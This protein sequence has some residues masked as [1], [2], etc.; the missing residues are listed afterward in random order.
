MIV[1]GNIGSE[2]EARKSRVGGDFYTF[3]LAENS[4]KGQETITTWYDAVAFFSQLDADLYRKGMFVK[5]FGVVEA[6]VYQPKD[7]TKP[8]RAALKLLVLKVE[9]MDSKQG[10]E[11]APAAEQGKP[12]PATP[13]TATAQPARVQTPVAA[14][15]P[16][17]SPSPVQ[18]KP[19]NKPTEVYAGGNFDDFGDD[20]VPF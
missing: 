11:G 16:A 17:P 4:K 14:V 7:T 2:I 12:E 6:S 13:A 19:L 10:A 5:I 15:A 9:L 1:F 8:P 18:A 3:R 20:D